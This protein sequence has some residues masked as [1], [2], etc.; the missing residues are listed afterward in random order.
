[1]D[2]SYRNGREE[3]CV[4][5]AEFVSAASGGIIDFLYHDLIPGMTPLEIERKVLENVEMPRS[6]KNAIFAEKDGRLVGAALSI[7]SSHHRITEEM[8][9][10]FPADRLEH[11]KHLFSARVE[12]SLLLDALCTDEE[13]RGQGVGTQLI[14]LTKQKAVDA[15]FHLLSLIVFADNTNAQRLYEHCGFEVVEKIEVKPH[16]LIPHEGG[17]LLMRCEIEP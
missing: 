13:S 8:K 7:P 12:N 3:D 17:C 2:I 9:A 6:Y 11:L 16:A 15:G 14:S 10:F 4:A 1:M 5:L